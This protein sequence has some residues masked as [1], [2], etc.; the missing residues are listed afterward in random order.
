MSA[1]CCVLVNS[2]D[3]DGVRQVSESGDTGIEVGGR[4]GGPCLL[5]VSPLPSLASFAP[6]LCGGGCFVQVNSCDQ[7]GARHVFDPAVVHSFMQDGV[8]HLLRRR[9]FL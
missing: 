9:Q 4:S 3:Q 7:V 1:I 2:C 6:V 8:R 5:R